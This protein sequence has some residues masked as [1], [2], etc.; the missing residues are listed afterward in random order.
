MILLGYLLLAGKVRTMAEEDAIRTTIGKHFKRQI[1]SSSLFGHAE[2]SSHTT[3]D[4]LSSLQHS[5]QS[6][7]FGHL[8]WTQDLKRLA[9][10]LGRAV[11][12][13]E[14]VLLVGETG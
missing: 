10:L 13:D 2:Q 8:V 1:I 3:T 14:P 11:E 5:Q 4:I 7:Q 9:V 12:F 6:E